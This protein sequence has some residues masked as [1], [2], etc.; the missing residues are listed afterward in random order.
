[1]SYVK[2]VK[3]VRR[4]SV[5]QTSLFRSSTPLNSMVSNSFEAASSKHR[6]YNNYVA[7]SLNVIRPICDGAVA[8]PV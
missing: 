6:S 1:M 3:F 7:A 5:I 8:Q 2:L 4:H